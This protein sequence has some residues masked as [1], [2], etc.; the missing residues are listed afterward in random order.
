AGDAL[1]EDALD[2]AHPE[3][4][5][6]GGGDGPDDDAEVAALDLAIGDEVGRDAAREVDGDGEPV[7]LVGPALGG[8]GR[9]DADDLPAE[10]GQGAAGVAVV[11]GGVGLD[12]V[13]YAEGVLDDVVLPPERRDVTVRDGARQ[14]E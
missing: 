5:R 9:G 2:P 8:D 7:P 10:V 4:L 14:A 13:L 1:D 12:E 3:L 6:V 11:D